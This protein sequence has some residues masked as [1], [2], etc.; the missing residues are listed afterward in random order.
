[1][2]SISRV[3]MLAACLLS[4]L[5]EKCFPPPAPPEMPPNT[6]E[7][8]QWSHTLLTAATH[9]LQWLQ[10]RL[11]KTNIYRGDFKQKDIKWQ[12]LIKGNGFHI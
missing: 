7:R 9:Y 6:F 10:R 12:A 8:K 2:D 5:G 1:M 3:E 11:P 4:V